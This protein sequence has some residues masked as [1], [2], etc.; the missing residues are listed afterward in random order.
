MARVIPLSQQTQQSEAFE[1]TDLLDEGVSGITSE[2]LFT[3]EEV[4]AIKGCEHFSDEQ[5]KEVIST[6]STFAQIIIDNMSDIGTV[7]GTTIN[8]DQVQNY[9]SKAA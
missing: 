2:E 8:I 9:T 3:I 5:A 7:V 4:R 1:N 6:L